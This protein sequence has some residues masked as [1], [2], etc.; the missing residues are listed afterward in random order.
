MVTQEQQLAGISNAESLLRCKRTIYQAHF[1]ITLFGQRL[2]AYFLPSSK[3]RI[4]SPKAAGK[5]KY[6]TGTCEVDKTVWSCGMYSQKI[7]MHRAKAIAGKRYKFWVFLL[8]AGGCWNILKRRVRI[9][10]RLNHCLPC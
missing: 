2:T 7:A 4:P 8:K 5:K 1:A 9:A 6:S 3:S 10:K